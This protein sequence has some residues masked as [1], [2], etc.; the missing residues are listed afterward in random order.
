MQHYIGPLRKF[1]FLMIPIFGAIFFLAI[2][3]LAFRNNESVNPLFVLVD[4]AMLGGVSVMP[5][6]LYRNYL[7]H[8]KDHVLEVGAEGFRLRTANKTYDI[9]YEE[10]S[11]IEEFMNTS[12]TP[13]YYCEYW[14]LQT[15]HGELILSSLLITRNDFFVRF[16]VQD[17]LKRQHRFMPFIQQ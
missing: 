16:P 15:A 3:I 5:F 7:K 10:I 9:K 8:N 2:L 1:Q 6:L 14:V 11:A 13:W 17:K 4:I 12:V